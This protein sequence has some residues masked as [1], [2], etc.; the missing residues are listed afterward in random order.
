M[1]RAVAGSILYSYVSGMRAI[2]G[3]FTNTADW[4]I[5]GKIDE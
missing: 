3:V 4:N 2:N 5:I 1:K